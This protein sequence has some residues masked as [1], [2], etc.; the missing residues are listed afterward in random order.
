MSH[1]RARIVRIA[2][3]HTSRALRTRHP[4][5]RSLEHRRCLRDD[6]R[7]FIAELLHDRRVLLDA[8]PKPTRLVDRACRAPWRNGYKALTTADDRTL[9]RSARLQRSEPG[10]AIWLPADGR[11]PHVRRRSSARIRSLRSA[12]SPY[13][14]A[15]RRLRARHRCS[16]VPSS[17]I[18]CSASRSARTV[19]SASRQPIASR[20]VSIVPRALDVAALRQ[21]RTTRS[22]A[23][24]TSS[25]RPHPT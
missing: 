11:E 13:R 24:A 16:P 15:R 14:L 7:A 25:T 8:P 17:S 19:S 9:G 21:R 20:R 1:E 6:A 23:C 2:H 4:T 22:R 18:S 3:R 12:I 10:D 5:A